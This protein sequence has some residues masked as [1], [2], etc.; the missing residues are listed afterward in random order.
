[1]TTSTSAGSPRFTTSIA[2]RIAGAR[3]FGFS[4]G[5]ALYIPYAFASIA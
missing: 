5:P 4:I 3:S 2:L 1:V